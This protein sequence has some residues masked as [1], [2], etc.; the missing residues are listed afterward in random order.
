[1][2]INVKNDGGK[3]AESAY[4]NPVHSTNNHDLHTGPAN[5]VL[6]TSSL[7]DKSL[8]QHSLISHHLTLLYERT[9]SE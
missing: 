7:I 4:V 2:K 5:I 9:D 8:K 6:L 1:M 3:K